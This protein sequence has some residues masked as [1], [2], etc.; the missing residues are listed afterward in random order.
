[1]PQG[2]SEIG[3]NAFKGCKNVTL[4]VAE[5]TYAE[6]YAKENNIPYVTRPYVSNVIATGAC[7]ESA[8]W[9]LYDSGKLVISGSGAVQ[10]YKSQLVTPWVSY[11]DSIKAIEIGAEITSIGRYAF[12]H[13]YEVKSI[14]F[15]EGSKVEKID[16]TGFY[17]DFN[18]TAIV[19]P[20][21]VRSIGVLAFG[22]QYA[23]KELYV[24]Q[25]VSEIGANAFKSCRNLTLNVAAGSYAE[26]YAKEN[27][28]PYTTR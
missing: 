10:D 3:N 28:I 19:L 16:V 14:A 2:V 13:L 8:T 23:L 1:M 6:T 27:N 7:G 22:N 9:T 25:G 18:V 17:Y 21:T 26:A 15:A 12:S 20:E 24:P 11:R 5:G 4:N